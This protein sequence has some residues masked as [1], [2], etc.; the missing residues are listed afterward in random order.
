MC[1]RAG[2]LLAFVPAEHFRLASGEDALSEY[3]FNKKVI[4]H[5]FC[6]TCGIK[7]FARGTGPDGKPMVAVNVRCLDD[8]DVGALTVQSFDGRSM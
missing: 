4:A 6:S 3:R 2:T 5:L 8:V 1:S 7:P